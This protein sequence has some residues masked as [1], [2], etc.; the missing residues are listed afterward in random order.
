M[1]PPY[2]CLLVSGGHTQII[3]CKSYGDYK[4][5]GETID[6]ACGEAFDKVGKLLNLEYPG[7]PKVSKLAE[8]EKASIDG[9]VK[10]DNAVRAFVLKSAIIRC[11]TSKGYNFDIYAGLVM[12]D[13]ANV[14]FVRLLLRL[15]QKMQTQPKQLM[16][17]LILQQRDQQL[18][19]Q[20]L[21]PLIQLPLQLK[22][23]QL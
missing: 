2:L 22:F 12:A 1:P 5:I 18:Q 23:L 10:S 17:F 13:K 16:M 14:Q 19:S 21:P 15:L 20:A 9:Q 4:I 7:G 6:D 11:L 3:D 8:S